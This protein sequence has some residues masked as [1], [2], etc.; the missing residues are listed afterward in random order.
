MPGWQVRIRV[1][2]TVGEI[3]RLMQDFSVWVKRR[4]DADAK[5]QYHTQLCALEE[6]VTGLLLTLRQETQA[7]A[8]SEISEAY[9][10]CRLQERRQLWVEKNLWGFYQQ[11]FDQRDQ[12]EQ[13]QIL[14]TAD[15]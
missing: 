7:G 14:E 8:P 2:Q 1:S 6:L 11:K 13:A 12:K 15:D 9:Q 10:F 3:D 5:H 4:L